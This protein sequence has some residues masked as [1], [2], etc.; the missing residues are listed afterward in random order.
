MLIR[1]LV[2]QRDHTGCGI[3]VVAM[4]GGISYQAAKP[5]VFPDWQRRRSFR[6]TPAQLLGALDR[7]GIKVGNRKL[8]RAP[9]DWHRLPGCC[10]AAVNIVLEAGTYPTRHWVLWAQDKRGWR[11]YCPDGLSSPDWEYGWLPLSYI[12]IAGF[13][14]LN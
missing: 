14:A 10:I 1:R 3:A 9:A 4:V 8:Q 12:E 2:R 6:S 5:L 11:V 7:L 13:P